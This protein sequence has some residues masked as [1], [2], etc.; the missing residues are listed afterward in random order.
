MNLLKSGKNISK[1]E[2]TN[3]SEHGFWILLSGKEYYLPFEKYPWF[4]D[5]KISTIF[6]VEVFN[7]NHLFWR[8][9]DVDLSI[10]ILENPD[11]YPL[12]YE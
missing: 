1:A 11:N 8:D 5:A 4:K 7:N 9:L 2:I 6:N 10:K 3:I 12:I